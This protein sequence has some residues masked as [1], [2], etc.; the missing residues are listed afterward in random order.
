MPVFA[1]LIHTNPKFVWSRYWY[2]V[3]QYSSDGTAPS[4]GCCTTHK[5]LWLVEYDCSTK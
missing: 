1:V 3:V 2:K 5:D 4:T